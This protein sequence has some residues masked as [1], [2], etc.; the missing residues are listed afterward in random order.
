MDSIQAIGAGLI[1]H[2]LTTLGGVLVADGLMKGGDV[3]TFVGAGMVMAGV[4]WSWWQKVGQAKVLA[5]LQSLR[6][7]ASGVSSF[8]AG[9]QAK[10]S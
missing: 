5:E 6:A 7:R 2:G 8:G 10:K 4:A 9:T 3:N 1:R